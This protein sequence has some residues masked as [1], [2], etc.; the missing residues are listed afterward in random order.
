[1]RASCWGV[2]SERAWRCM[3]DSGSGG[4]SILRRRRLTDRDMFLRS[5]VT[6]APPGIVATVVGRIVTAASP[7]RT[8]HGNSKLQR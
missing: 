1:V 5:S 7:G 2:G 8:F 3:A 4:W 6:A